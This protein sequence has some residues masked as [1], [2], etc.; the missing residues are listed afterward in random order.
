VG[1][2]L[3]PKGGQNPVEPAA[4]GKPVLFGP[5]M[6]DFSDIADLM[7]K[8]G[9]AIQ[10]NTGEEFVAEAYRLLSDSALSARLG[11][12]NRALVERH[13]G[14]TSKIAKDILECLSKA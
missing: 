2:S 8:E 10:V 9:G 14:V 13:S 11:R 6:S 7:R 1:G 4:A 5:D 12:K 3:V